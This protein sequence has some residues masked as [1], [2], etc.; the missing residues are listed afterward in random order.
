MRWWMD[1]EMIIRE[2]ELSLEESEVDSVNGKVAS[3]GE[4]DDRALRETVQNKFSAFESSMKV[5][6]NNNQA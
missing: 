2:E 4:K 1:K 5:N 3:V 6:G